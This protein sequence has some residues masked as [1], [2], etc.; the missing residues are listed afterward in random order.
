MV[1]NDGLAG[2]YV[3]NEIQ[4]SL[5]QIN[6]TLILKSL[7]LPRTAEHCYQIE[8]DDRET[9]VGTKNVDSI[10]LNTEKFN[11][12][13]GDIL[14]G[15]TADKIHAPVQRAFNHQYA[16]SRTKFLDAPGGTRKPFTIRRTKAI[17]KADKHSV[18]PSLLMLKQLHYSR[19]VERRIQ[20]SKC[21]FQ[22]TMIVYIIF[23]WSLRSAMNSE[24]L[25]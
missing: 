11:T 20:S 24:K 8:V 15:L 6:P 3:L 18:M 10:A 14:A 9:L 16:C 1:L 12:I 13:V 21:P 7:N 23:P 25:L 22:F 2:D 5:T 4:N 17:I 19:I